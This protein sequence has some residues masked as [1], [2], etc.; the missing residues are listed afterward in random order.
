MK[1]VRKPKRRH[2]AFM[3]SRVGDHQRCSGMLD[4]G[5]PIGRMPCARPEGD[6][7]GWRLPPEGFH[8]ALRS[9]WPREAFRI[10]F[11]RAAPILLEPLMRIV[12][13]TPEDYLGSIMRDD[14][15]PP[16]A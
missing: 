12:V 11:E 6:V 2:N 13:T 5:I 4:I 9:S 3:A 16:K 14:M 7:A 10:G 8:P 1:V 15:V